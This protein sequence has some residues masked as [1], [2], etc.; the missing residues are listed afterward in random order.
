MTVCNAR[1]SKSSP[2][3]PWV[4]NSLMQDACAQIDSRFISVATGQDFRAPIINGGC[5]FTTNGATAIMFG[6]IDNIHEECVSR[7]VD[8]P[9]QLDSL[10]FSKRGATIASTEP[11]NYK[12]TVERLTK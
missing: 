7:D 1:P 2:Y 4:T 11:G 9:Q 8:W 12:V 3:T 5:V 6:I 10:S